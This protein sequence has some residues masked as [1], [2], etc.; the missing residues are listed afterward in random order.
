MTKEIT[1]TPFNFPDGKVSCFFDIDFDDVRQQI[2]ASRVIYVTDEHIYAAY[3]EKFPVGETIILPSGEDAKNMETVAR[4]IDE[5]LLM[6]ADRETFLLGVGGGVVTDITG[7]LASIYLRGIRFS[8][9]PTTVLAMVDASIGGKNGVNVEEVKNQIGIIRQPEHLFFDYQF[10]N[11]L[12]DVEWVSGFGEIIK[13]AC[14]RDKEMFET[15]EQHDIDDFRKDLNLMGALVKRNAELK[16]SVA[17]EDERESGVRRMLNFGHTVGHAVEKI[18]SIPHGLAIS[19]G[20]RYGCLLSEK[21]SGL[22]HDQ[23]ERILS[24]MEKYHFPYDTQVDKDKAWDLMVHDKKRVGD[25]LYYILLKEI[26]EGLVQ[27]LTL[28]EFKELFYQI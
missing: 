21:L 16:Y 15:L 23:T 6:E 24:L 26:G 10:L 18:K 3:A 13:H 7:F 4:A 25:S 19:V 8:F 27:K 5:L 22:S 1:M 11:T 2:D 14:I 17:S 28:E 9:A 20:I 12:E